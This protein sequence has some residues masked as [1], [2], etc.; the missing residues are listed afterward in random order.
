MRQGAYKPGEATLRMKM[1]MKSGNPYM[2]DVVAY[3]VLNKPHVRTGDKWLIYP[4]Y[5][6]SHCLT[7]SIENITHSL[8]TTEFT[9]AREAYFWVCDAVKVSTALH[10]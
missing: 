10:C 7:D 6:F 3:R 2:W 9:L 4:T 1:D 5:D 8:C